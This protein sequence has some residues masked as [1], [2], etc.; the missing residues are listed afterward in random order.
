ME[1][2]AVVSGLRARDPSGQ[3]GQSQK[4]ALVDIPIADQPL[5]RFLPLRRGSVWR[6][7]RLDEFLG[8]G[9]W[10]GRGD[11]LS[12]FPSPAQLLHESWRSDQQSDSLTRV[13]C[14]DLRGN[15]HRFFGVLL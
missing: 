1:A 2:K 4:S 7:N 14:P 13:D 3:P 6:G 9:A 15:R 11:G 5:D 10:Q 12:L 8:R